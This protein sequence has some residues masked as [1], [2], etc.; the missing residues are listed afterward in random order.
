MKAPLQLLAVV[1][2]ALV[3]GVSHAQQLAN[4]YSIHGRVLD[5]QN[6]SPIARVLVTIPDKELHLVV[7][8]NDGRFELEGIHTEPAQLRVAK[9]GYFLPGET[10]LTTMS[11]T[12]MLVN[13][14]TKSIVLK[15]DAAS[16]IHGRII[17]EEGEALETVPITLFYRKPINGEEFV[18]RQQAINTNEDGE[19]NF[20][21]LPAGKY[22][23]LAG[24]MLGPPWM[25]VAHS[26]IPVLNYGA[27][28]YPGVSDPHA[29]APIV[30]GP[31]Q[32]ISIDLSLKKISL[33]T[34]SGEVTGWHAGEEGILQIFPSRERIPITI[35][36][37]TWPQASFMHPKCLLG[38]MQSGSS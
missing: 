30:L 3:T 28:Y 36:S 2:I 11:N 1:I 19:F 24:P 37:L 32:D 25:P 12:S 31:G 26:K 18:L 27:A 16:T 21:Q 4:S 5:S 17:S 13:S 34:L 15:L 20:S 33:F 29:A 38:C 35:R 7:T 9:R 23:I 22:F 14:H 8:D 10:A 6:G